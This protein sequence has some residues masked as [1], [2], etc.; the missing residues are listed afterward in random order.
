[1]N[2]AARIEHCT[3]CL[4]LDNL[5]A[6]K[7]AKALKILGVSQPTV[8]GD[9]LRVRYTLMLE[10]IGN[11]AKALQAVNEICQDPNVIIDA[12]SQALEEGQCLIFETFTN[13]KQVI[14]LVKRRSKSFW[15]RLFE[16][17]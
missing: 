16:R 2:K 7:H 10:Y 8:E 13:L 3:I 9:E 17:I 12:N 11:V 1:M 15:K 5:A 6:V 4:N 14:K